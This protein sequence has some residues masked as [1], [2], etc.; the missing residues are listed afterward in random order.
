M[1]LPIVVGLGDLPAVRSV[2]LG[3][4]ITMFML[5]VPEAVVANMCAVLAAEAVAPSLSDIEI[6]SR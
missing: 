5:K 4:P 6:I 1:G 3:C 2:M